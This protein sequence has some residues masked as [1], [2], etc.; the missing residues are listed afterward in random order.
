[1]DGGYSVAQ[2]LNHEGPEKLQGGI[3]I[4]WRERCAPETRTQYMTES[5]RVKESDVEVTEARG[6]FI[7]RPE[8]STILLSGHPGKPAHMLQKCN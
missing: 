7:V 5:S 2:L 8:K 1:M 3:D 6:Y 4:V